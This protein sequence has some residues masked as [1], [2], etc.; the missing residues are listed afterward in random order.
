[1]T[2]MI[3]ADKIRK[4][5]AAHRDDASSRGGMILADLKALFTSPSP[6]S[7]IIR[8]LDDLELIDPDTVIAHP[9]GERMEPWT[10]GEVRESHVPTRL[11]P[12]VVIATARQ[13]R[14]AREA[15]EAPDA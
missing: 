4:I 15:L 5:I 14:A 1:M 11:L 6:D 8:T 9:I 13:L 10:A 12:A 7:Q 2:E 3:P